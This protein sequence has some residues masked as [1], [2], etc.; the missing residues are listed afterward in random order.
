MITSEFYKKRVSDFQHSIAKL[1]K[2]IQGYSWARL[3]VAL[4]LLP[5][6]YFGIK[7]SV[8]FY[9]V[10]PLLIL[11]I[12]LVRTYQ[13]LEE[14]KKLLLQLVNL[15]SFEAAA[16]DHDYSNFSDGQEFVDHTHPYSHDLDLFGKGSVFQY[17]NRSATSI[18]SR[19]LAQELSH[20]SFTKEEVIERQAAI[21][22]L[23]AQIEFRQLSWATGKLIHDSQFRLE[24]LYAWLQ[25]SP[26]LLGRRIIDIVKWVLPIITISMLIGIAFD[27][28][29]KPLFFFMLL[30]QLAIASIYAKPIARMQNRLSVYKVIM[31]NYSRLFL[32]MK[33]QTW[34][35]DILKRHH[36]IAT[37]AAAHVKEFSSLVNALE[38]RM[39][40]I[41]R[42]FGNGLFLYDFHSVSNLEKWRKQNAVSLPVWMKSLAEWDALLSYATLHFN[43][44]QYAFAEVGDEL[45]VSGKDV[46]HLLIPSSERIN[47]DTELGNPA[48]ILLITGANMAGKSTFLRTVGVNYV[49]AAVGSPVCASYW[50][51]SLA[52]LRSG[53]RTSDSLQEHSSYFYAELNRL[54]SIIEDLRAGKPLVILLDEILKG[55]NS[56]DKQ[57]GSRE[58]IK[59]LLHHQAIVL[60]AT[61]DVALGDLENQY[62][63]QVV[64]TC[65]EGKIENDQLTFDYKLNKG[66]AQRANA[67]FLMRKMGIIPTSN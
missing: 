59:Q 37:E 18:G 56:T 11:F 30:L 32:L 45:I 13:K 27:P 47:N 65:F 14:E 28:V 34:S 29:F 66:V 21:R 20:P 63:N 33:N 57:A 10:P 6:I 4:A 19:T 52:A 9:A 54:Q 12:F 38:S 3:V 67:T 40:M 42:M 31:D 36:H 49:L 2:K 16:V 17:I 41:A 8:Y 62:S 7:E 46:G 1:D 43:H 60:L 39:N 15:N 64:N 53:M 44:P 22:E 50:R 25:E 24:D 58:L 55:T 61:H 5:F 23:G 48:R 26:L 35:A 51:S